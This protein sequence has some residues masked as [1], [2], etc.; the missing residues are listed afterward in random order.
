MDATATY[1]A[2]CLFCLAKSLWASIS[3][4]TCCGKQ[5][6]H[7]NVCVILDSRYKPYIHKRDRGRL[8]RAQAK[9]M[10]ADKAARQESDRED[11]AL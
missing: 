8:A 11:S 10:E 4:L 3:G 6:Y 2:L 9:R 1:I 5:Q 7:G